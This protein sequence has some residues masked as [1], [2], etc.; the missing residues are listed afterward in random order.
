M[1]RI[2]MVGY[3]SNKGGVEAYIS[4]LC[5]CLDRSKYEVIYSL[6]TMKID[7]KTWQAP[8]NRHNYIK[9]QLFWSRFFKENHFDVLYYNACDIV[10]IDMLRFAKKAGIPVRIIHAHSTGVEQKLGVIHTFLEKRNHHLLKD[11][12][13]H[14]FACAKETGKWM[15]DDHPFMIVENG[16]DLSE[17]SF[18]AEK[19]SEQRAYIGV[20]DQILIGCVGRLESVKNLSFAVRLIEYMEN[21]NTKVHLVFIGEGTMQSQLEA[22]IAGKQLEKNATFL[23]VRDDVKD[24]YSAFDCLLMPSLFE[25]LPFVLVEAQA[26]GLPCVVSSNISE[27]ANL[28]GLVH[29]VGLNE[30]LQTWADRIESV[31]GKERPDTTQH[32]IDAG[33]SIEDTAKTV[34][35]IIEQALVE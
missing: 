7:G 28:T 23:G 25:G 6:P 17:F 35:D 22:E 2:F 11:Y 12:A 8:A 33:Y 3:S 34:S 14:F 15:F 5:G 24:W 21:H 19:R 30:P 32:L 26:S 1:I 9:Y 18:C 4:N 13:T 27:E 10:S 29:Y 20:G 31:C 16:I